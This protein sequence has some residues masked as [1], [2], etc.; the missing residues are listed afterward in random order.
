MKKNQ[1]YIQGEWISSTGTESSKVINPATEEVI[2]EVALGTKEDVDKAVQAAKTAFPKWSS[3]PVE[4]R[5]EYM[6]KIYKY[7]SLFHA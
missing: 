1:I 4:E 5:I 2:G 3:L 7:Y 6:E